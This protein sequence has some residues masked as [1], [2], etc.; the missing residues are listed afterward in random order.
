MSC[1]DD[2]VSERSGLA[3][4]TQKPSDIHTEESYTPSFK[5]VQSEP[6]SFLIF[7][8]LLCF[9]FKYVEPNRTGVVA[10]ELRW[11]SRVSLFFFGG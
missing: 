2:D 4:F 11:G 10:F 8:E 9:L 6:I 7:H 3:K 1:G 5:S